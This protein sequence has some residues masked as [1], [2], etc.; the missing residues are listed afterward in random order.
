MSNR[1]KGLIQASWPHR[2]QLQGTSKYRPLQGGP[3]HEMQQVAGGVVSYEVLEEARA[4]RGSG[5]CWTKGEGIV[6][7]A[8]LVQNCDCR[9]QAARQRAPRQYQGESL[10]RSS[11]TTPSY[12]SASGQLGCI[13]ERTSAAQFNR[14]AGYEGE[15][16][17][18]RRETCCQVSVVALAT[19]CCPCWSP[20]QA[21]H[22]CLTRSTPFPF[23]LVPIQFSTL[24]IIS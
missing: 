4:P 9:G 10:T 20:A 21:A 12:A 7:R 14:I 5:H 23:P 6:R 3:R 2:L 8:A 18:A 22:P 24:T 13:P 1:L 19:A 16:S 11:L 15:G 17:R